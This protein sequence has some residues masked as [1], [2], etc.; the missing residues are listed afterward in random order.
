MPFRKFFGGGTRPDTPPPGEPSP[1]DDDEQYVEPELAPEESEAIDWRARATRV[2]PTGASTGS[3]RPSALYGSDDAHGPTHFSSA[4]GCRV[5]D[6]DGVEFVDCTM[7]LGSVALGYAEPEVTRAVIAAAGNGN[8]S[9][10]S[11][12]REIELAERLCTVIPCA[13]MAQ[14]LKT[15]AEATSAAIRLARASTGRERV[16]GCGYFGWHDWSSAADGV[17]QD[18]RRAYT[19]IAFNDLPALESAVAAAGSSLA[20]I[21]I[22]PVI[23]EM[24]DER[25]IAR[26]RELATQAGAV[27]I[28]DE[29]KTGFRLRTGGYQELSGVTPDLATF[30]KAM[31][32]GYPLAAVV[33]SRA[34]MES[35]R[36]TWISSTLASESTAIAAAHAVLDWHEKADI[37]SSLGEIG[38]E[39]RASIDAA[40]EA[41]GIQGVSIGG[42]DHM[43]FL[44]WDSPRRETR[45]L[46]L[47]ASYGVLV[48]RGPYNFPAIA[49]HD[50]IIR[51]IESGINSAFVD[52]RDEDEGADPDDGS[53]D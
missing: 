27:L 23:E 41:S 13:E 5:T 25:W 2:L 24:P 53:D 42:I 52:L 32:N 28:F 19:S 17:P 22:E 6:A 26:A 1:A 21:I 34:V 15:G 50:A 20:A 10:L 18:T 7:A 31:A 37:A 43:W 33:G 4:V 8:V 16:V 44:R 39:I 3:K 38:A 30:G 48:K 46:E 51:E 35:A 40:R 29:I 11:D 9:G 47:A 36:T 49:H 14:F 45:F 12:Y